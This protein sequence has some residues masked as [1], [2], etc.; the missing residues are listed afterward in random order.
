M[1]NAEPTPS[2]F[3]AWVPND[4]EINESLSNTDYPVGSDEITHTVGPYATNS[5]DATANNSGGSSGGGQEDIVKSL[6]AN[7]EGKFDIIVL[8]MQEAAFVNKTNKSNKDHGNNND[9][10]TKPDAAT[11]SSPNNN[12]NNGDDDSGA[13]A[14]AG[15]GASPKKEKSKGGFLQKGAK[16]AAKVGMVVRG[17][18]ANQTYQ[19]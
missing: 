1:G 14:A 2:S 5:T 16:K 15:G 8:G 7:Q 9:T 3:A 10:P 13:A 18:S 12:D 6:Q 4:G 19:R 11:A 17:I